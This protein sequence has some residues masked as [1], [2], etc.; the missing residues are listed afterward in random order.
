LRLSLLATLT[1]F[2]CSSCYAGSFLGRKFNF[3]RRC[4][5]AVV[6]FQ[7][8]HSAASCMNIRCRMFRATWIISVSSK[9]WAFRNIG[10]WKLIGV[11][12]TWNVTHISFSCA[13]RASVSMRATV[14]LYSVTAGSPSCGKYRS[15]EQPKIGLALVLIVKNWDD[16]SVDG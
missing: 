7:S 1:Q 13:S 12:S 3:E 6:S 2:Q 16:L 15:D 11:R 5:S 8:L 9:S 14:I 4:S 10:I